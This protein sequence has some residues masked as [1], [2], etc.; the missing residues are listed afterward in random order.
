[1]LPIP[2]LIKYFP[3]RWLLNQT[4]SRGVVRLST[5][6]RF[7][8]LA[9]PRGDR[10]EGAKEV[11]FALEHTE[12]FTGPEF[13]AGLPPGVAIRGVR[14]GKHPFVEIGKEA[15]V[16]LGSQV[17]RDAYIFCAS[18]SS[19]IAHF[20]AFS[21]AIHDCKAFAIAVADGLR[22]AG[23]EIEGCTIGPI[24]YSDDQTVTI[25]NRHNLLSLSPSFLAESDTADYFAKPADN[26]RLR[27]QGNSGRRQ[28]A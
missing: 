19:G 15:T 11:R 9:A 24:Y 2:T 13:A 5:L 12:R 23:V 25:R 16:A 26:G 21:Y 27:S 6:E 4:A 8:T 18:A 20:G 22:R 28:M 1:M 14:P 7:R 17:P 10:L 3:E